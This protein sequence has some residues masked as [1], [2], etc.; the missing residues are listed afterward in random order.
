[1]NG[2]IASTQYFS[3]KKIFYAKRDTLLVS[4]VCF[5]STYSVRGGQM[6]LKLCMKQRPRRKR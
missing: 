6:T 4:P 5:I 2:A 3:T 1:M